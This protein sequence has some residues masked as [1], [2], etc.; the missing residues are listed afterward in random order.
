MLPAIDWPELT[1]EELAALEDTLT[2][3]KQRRWALRRPRSFVEA[4]RASQQRGQR[5]MR[6][7]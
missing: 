1:E 5:E 4:L 6:D 7:A 2:A 3:E